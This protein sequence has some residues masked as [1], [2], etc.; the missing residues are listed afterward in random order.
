MAWTSTFSPAKSLGLVG[1]SGSGKSVTALSILRLIP[2]PPGKIVDGSILFK[3]RDLLKLSWD[4]IRAVRGKEISMIFQEPMT[5]LNP[6]FT[7]GMQVMEAV[8]G[9]EQ[10][11]QEGSV[12]AIRRDAGAGGHSGPGVAHERLSAAVFRRHAAARDDRHGAGL[13]SVAADRRRADDRSGRHHP[14]ANSGTDAADQGPAEGR[15]DS[16]DHAQ[17]RRGGGDLPSRDRHVR[18]ENSGSGAG[19]GAIQESAASVHAR[20][21]GIV[22]DRRRREAAAAYDDSGQRAQHSR[23]ARR[24]QIRRRAAASGSNDAL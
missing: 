21:A 24:L 20:S 9:H 19:E 10:V 15:G 18:R 4:E 3:G 16:A 11:S 17:S 2:D 12:P 6:V 7:I 5:S 8:L 13:Q 1:E 22:A 23:S 14:G